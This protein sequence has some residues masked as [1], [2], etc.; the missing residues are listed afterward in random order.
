MR[1]ICHPA[2][3]TDM[4]SVFDQVLLAL[5][6]LSL[7][8]LLLYANHAM[9]AAKALW[10]RRLGGT[11]NDGEVE[12]AEIRLPPG[13]RGTTGLGDAP[14]QITDRRRRRFLI[15]ISESRE[16]FTG[17]VDLQEF[18]RLTFARLI[19]SVK[20]LEVHEPMTCKVAT[21]EALQ[22]EFVAIEGDRFVIKYLF[23][24]IAGHR[25]FHQVIAWSAQSAYDRA[26]FLKLLDRFRERPGPPVSMRHSPP[27]HASS[28]ESVH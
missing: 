27:P 28:S 24:V 8:G 25:A 2:D 7:L 11:L 26:L 16:D 18:H 22:S 6:M 20:I 13:W 23:T 19:A 14:I 15:V 12:L 1:D 5:G 9:D 17:N 3:G 21:F 4:A 10:N